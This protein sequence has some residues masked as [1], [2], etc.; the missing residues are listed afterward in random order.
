MNQ[1]FALRKFLSARP[2]VSRRI[3]NLLTS[4]SEGGALVEMALVVP[5]M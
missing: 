3:K 2:H 1:I 5:L 4:H